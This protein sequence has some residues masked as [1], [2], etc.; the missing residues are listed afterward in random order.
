MFSFRADSIYDVIKPFH[1]CCQLIGLVAFSI[2]KNDGQGFKA[3]L[4]LGNVV[5]FLLSTAWT[6]LI[7]VLYVV[8]SGE[9]FGANRQHFSIVFEKS[10]VAVLISYIIIHATSNWW[11]LLY[12]KRFA[13]LVRNIEDTDT[14]LTKYGCLINFRRHKYFIL[15]FLQFCILSPILP[16]YFSIKLAE[17][18]KM[19]RVNVVALTSMYFFLVSFILLMTQFAFIIWAVKMRYQNVNG[20]LERQFLM[21]FNNAINQSQPKRERLNELAIIHDKLVDASEDISCCYGVPVSLSLVSAV[22]AH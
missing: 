22:D 21:P 13:S 8:N 17:E 18:T 14:I 15:F 4:S 2:R 9:V 11:L 5:C 16:I 19:Y 6:V 7:T 12:R 20:A 10:I 1:I 3:F